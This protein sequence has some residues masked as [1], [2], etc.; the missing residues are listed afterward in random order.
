MAVLS[1]D[2]LRQAAGNLPTKTIA[3]PALG[4]GAE[5]TI[6]ALTRAQHL[7]A[8]KAAEITIPGNPP[9]T[10][11]DP[12]LLEA[13]LLLAGIVEP[14]ITEDDIPMLRNAASGVVQALS[15]AIMVLS[16]IGQKVGEAVKSD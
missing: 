1:L 13:R 16:G 10:D 14:A 2:Q 4:D 5:V 8:V 6:R 15:E 12:A 11:T 7:A 9:R 3:V